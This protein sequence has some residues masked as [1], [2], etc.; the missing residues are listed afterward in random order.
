MS[1]KNIKTKQDYSF[2]HVDL[3]DNLKENSRNKFLR[4]KSKN[5]DS[6]KRKHDT[7]N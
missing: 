5:K 4:K 6:K 7:W 2:M 3:T 1:K